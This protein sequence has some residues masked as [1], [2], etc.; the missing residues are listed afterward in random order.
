MKQTLKVTRISTFL[1]AAVV[2]S[3]HGKQSVG[4]TRAVVR[5]TATGLFA[6]HRV[7]ENKYVHPYRQEDWVKVAVVCCEKNTVIIA[8]LC[9]RPPFNDPARH[10][11]NSRFSGRILLST[12]NNNRPT[13][14]QR[15]LSFC[16]VG[17]RLM[18]TVKPSTSR[19]V[20][21]R[22]KSSANSDPRGSKNPPTVRLNYTCDFVKAD[23]YC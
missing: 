14:A 12:P 9:V 20:R 10:V 8:R 4:P 16:A 19:G 11:H 5:P 22:A 1:K 3:V 2:R 6:R 15:S 13:L 18:P 21:M 23:N 17:C 7:T